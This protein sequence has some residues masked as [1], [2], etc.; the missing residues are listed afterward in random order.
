MKKKKVITIAAVPLGIA[1]LGGSIMLS[2]Y[3]SVVSAQSQVL[4]AAE[5]ATKTNLEYIKVTTGD[6][7]SV[8][9]YTIRI[10]DKANLTEVSEDY[11]NGV[12]Q[13]KIIISEKGSKVTSIGRDFT[14]NE[15]TGSTWT[16]PE[17]LS[18]ENER[19]LKISL[20]E[21]Q[22]QQVTG[23]DWVESKDSFTK[24]GYKTAVSELKDRKD[25]VTIDE[26][27]GM[28]VKKETFIKNE[29][30]IWKN[31]PSRVEEYKYLDSIPMNIMR[32]DENIEIKERPAPI[33]EDKLFNG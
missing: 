32:N 12:L 7:P 2:S 9:S 27:N 10:R 25:V 28:L 8:Q 6:D 19:V 26:S 14:T 20:L 30:G 4:S 29:D 22:K 15:M 17:N 21:E 18:K 23:Q 24:S 33:I 1:I 16:L 31:K 13:S 3:D 11:V 5:N